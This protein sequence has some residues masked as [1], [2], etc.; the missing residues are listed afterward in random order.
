MDGGEAMTFTIPDW[1]LLMIA[2]YIAGRTI[3][4]G[5]KFLAYLFDLRTSSTDESSGRAVK[6]SSQLDNPNNTGGW[7]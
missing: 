2:G 1:A 7:E 6:R 4:A 3:E 5:L